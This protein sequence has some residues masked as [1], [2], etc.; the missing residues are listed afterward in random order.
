MVL[1]K[2]HTT[3]FAFRKY[4]KSMDRYILPKTRQLNAAITGD[5][6][7]TAKAWMESYICSIKKEKD[8]VNQAYYN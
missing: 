4:Y 7:F 5:K 8:I 2:Y 1:L 6:K 3:D